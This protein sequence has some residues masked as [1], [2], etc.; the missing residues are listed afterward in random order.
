MPY[1]VILRGLIHGDGIPI[2]IYSQLQT[3]AEAWLSNQE[4]DEYYVD[5][6]SKKL[7]RK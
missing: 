2:F 7:L 5:L 6:E 3:L 1:H 4:I